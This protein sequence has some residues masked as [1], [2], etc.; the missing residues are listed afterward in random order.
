MSELQT[1]IN[2]V[3]AQ[4]AG[5]VATKSITTSNILSYSVEIM[6]IVEQQSAL[7]GAQKQSVVIGVLQQ[8][9]SSSSI[10]VGDQVLLNTLITSLVPGF[11]SIV[12]S[13]CKG[14]Y[15]INKEVEAQCCAWMT[16]CKAK[17]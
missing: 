8:T 2:G 11:I 6:E 14:I 10:P 15:N 7:T 13:A 5:N 17:K 1:I 12:C 3:I 16:S 9:V 4:V